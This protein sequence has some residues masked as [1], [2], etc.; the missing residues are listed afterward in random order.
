MSH[1]GRLESAKERGLGCFASIVLEDMDSQTPANPTTAEVLHVVPQPS[2]PVLDFA[3]VIIS[4]APGREGYARVRDKLRA[5]TFDEDAL[6]V[7]CFVC[8]RTFQHGPHRYGR[9]ITR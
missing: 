2:A 7:P 5:E 8:G 9:F 6:V 1:E 4:A 3:H